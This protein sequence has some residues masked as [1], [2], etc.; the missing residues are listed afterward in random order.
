[1]IVMKFG[2]TSVSSKN[3]IEQI[4][5]ILSKKMGNYLVVVSAF[6]GVTNTLEELGNLA[7]AG[8]FKNSLE[9]FRERHIKVIKEIVGLSDQTDLIMVVQQKCKELEQICQSIHILKEFSSRTQANILSIGEELSSLILCK[10]LNLQDLELEYLDSKKIIRANRDYLNGEVDF[11]TTNANITSSLAG[12]NYITGGFVASN[13]KGET[14]TLGRG[15][16][17]Y[18][19]AIYASALGADCLEIWSDVD[20]LHSANPRVVNNTKAIGE[21]SYEEALELAYFGAKVLYPPSVLPVMRDG[22]PLYLKNT[23]KPELEG[24]LV[25]GKNVP[26]E[27]KVLGLSSL[28]DMAIITVSGVGLARQKG[29]ARKIFQILEENEINIVLITQCCSEQSIGIGIAQND[30]PVAEVAIANE[31]DKEIQKGILN[32]PKVIQNQCIIALVGDNMKNKIGLS[33]RVF[34]AIGENGININAIAQGASERNISIV[35]DQAQEEKALNVIHEKFFSSSVKTIHLFIAGIGNVGKE[36]LKVIDMQR[37]HLLDDLK[38]R[39]KVVGV[40]NSKR[41]LINQ[42]D[43]ISSEEALNINETG[44]EYDSFEDYVE[45]IKSLN[46]SN[47][48]FIDNTASSIVSSAYPELLV[49][50]VSVIACNKIACSSDFDYYQKLQKLAKEYNAFFKYETAVGAALPIIKTIHDIRISGDQVNQIEAVISGS[51]N[52][53]FNQYSGERTFSEIVRQAKEEGYTEPDPLIDLSGLDVM[54]KI[55]I[56]SREAGYESE[57]SD[58]TFNHFLPEECSSAQGVDE[59]FSSLE[60][61][62]DHF[63][64]LYEKANSAGRKLKILA[65]MNEGKMKVELKEIEPESPLYNLEGKDNVVAINTNRYITEPMVIKGAGAGASITASGVFADLMHVV[66]R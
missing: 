32:T 1:M 61:H 11:D 36:F 45:E 16:S 31:F 43:G 41:F 22:I 63:K 52:F 5:S 35:I 56:L 10:Y 26:Q 47:S 34:S 58:I 24:T 55:L 19:A 28:K 50:S 4:K 29:R 6:S 44:K 46:L 18:T 54:R 30:L 13:S 59:L 27:D 12:K 51:L 33:G 66:N 21:L 15:G 38:I 39:L 48:I 25:S 20:G 9:A 7:L 57:M 23:F 37:E 3:S 62:E 49:E 64:A 17:D 65:S 40:S 8:D 14:V 60:K 42:K 2:G 53:I